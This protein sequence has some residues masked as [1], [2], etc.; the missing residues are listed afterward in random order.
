MSGVEDDSPLGNLSNDNQ[1]DLLRE[2]DFSRA[3]GLDVSSFLVQDSSDGKPEEVAEVSEDSTDKAIG[4][5][6]PIFTKQEDVT[7]GSIASDGTVA[8]QPPNDS[9]TNFAVY[10]ERRIGF[11]L[12]IAMI[13]SWSLIGTIVGTVLPPVFGAFGLTLMAVI[14]LYLG[15]R[16]IPNPQMRILGV[17]WVIISMKLI[18]GL[19]LDLWH[20]GWLSGFS[21]A[22]EMKFLVVY[23]SLVLGSI[24]WLASGMMKMLLPHKQYS[25]Y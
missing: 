5:I 2:R 23:Y 4:E 24:F 18:Y 19:M 12:L 10:G 7:A 9:V 6:S 8:E 1:D 15:E 21:V 25:F 22:G 13:L 16:W 3:R 14:G 17:T 20:W 11:G